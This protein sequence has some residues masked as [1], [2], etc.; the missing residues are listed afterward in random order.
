MDVALAAVQGIIRR[1][2]K[3]DKAM[4]VLV[5][6]ER[7]G[8]HNRCWKRC[9]NIMHRVELQPRRE[10]KS[11]VSY[12]EHLMH[13]VMKMSEMGRMMASGHGMYIHASAS[14]ACLA[15]AKRK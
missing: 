8:V 13:C 11:D 5:S 15:R 3:R 10:K 7:V 14:T 1:A 9:Y 6:V 4:I 2:R 12:R